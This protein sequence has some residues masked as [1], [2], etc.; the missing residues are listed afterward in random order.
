MR[1]TFVVVLAVAFMVS[2]GFAKGKKRQAPSERC[3]TADA[4]QIFD[5]LRPLTESCSRVG[6]ASARWHMDGGAWN[7]FSHDQQQQ[8]MDQVAARAAIQA[9]RVTIHV[10]VYSTDVGEIGPGWG[11]EWKFRRKSD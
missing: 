5:A 3:I 1:R 9:A 4:D 6:P 8:L 11:G 10:Y 2:P 7:G